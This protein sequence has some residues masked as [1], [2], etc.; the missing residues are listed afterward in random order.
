MVL[1]SARKAAHSFDRL[2]HLI[3]ILVVGLARG[4]CFMEN[5]FLPFSF[6]NARTQI[7]SIVSVSS[8]LLLVS[9]MLF[10]ATFHSKGFALSTAQNKG[11]RSSQHEFIVSA[12]DSIIGPC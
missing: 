4:F 12:T 1:A 10:L 5:S 7:P 11:E 8:K 9:I 2:L 6:D 3:C